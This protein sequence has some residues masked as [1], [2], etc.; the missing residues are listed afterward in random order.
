MCCDS[1]TT[2]DTLHCC[3]HV[4]LPA[5]LFAVMGLGDIVGL[6]GTQGLSEEQKC[7]VLSVAHHITEEKRRKKSMTAS[8]FQRVTALAISTCT[9][10]EVVNMVETLTGLIPGKNTRKKDVDL[11]AALEQRQSLDDT[12][13]PV[14]DAGLANAT[15]DNLDQRLGEVHSG[16]MNAWLHHIYND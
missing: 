5:L 1:L 8:A 13:C 2:I 11:M 3:L 10:N 16:A 15:F 6:H 14:W 7:S 9:K 4:Q 12:K